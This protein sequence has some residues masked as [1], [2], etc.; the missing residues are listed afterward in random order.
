VLLA[1]AITSALPVGDTKI[2]SG[3]GTWEQ[4]WAARE[5][6]INKHLEA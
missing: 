1:E 6:R 3:V 2:E 4:Q 5:Q